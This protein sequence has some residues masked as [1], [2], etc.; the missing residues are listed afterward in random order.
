[1]LP[2]GVRFQ[3]TL[4][5]TPLY[6]LHERLGGKLVPYAGFLMPVLYNGQLHVESH[7]WVRSKCGLFDVLH[8][9]QHR[10]SGPGARAFLE[11]V[12]PADLGALPVFGLTLLV[13][14][15]DKGGVVD[16]TIITKHGDDSFYFVTNAGCRDKDLAFLKAQR[17]PT[18][19]FTHTPFEG[20][21]I[22]LQGPLAA[23]T[24]Q[25]FTQTDLGKLVFGTSAFVDLEIAGKAHVA[26]G[27]YTGEDGFEI[28]I[29]DD[30]AAVAFTEALLAKEA[31]API[32][33]AA[34][35]S[36]RLE[37]GMCLYGHELTEDLTPVDA[38]LLWLVPK[39]RRSADAGF[40][41]A[42]RI[43]SQLADK[44][45]VKSVRVGLTSKGPA[46]RDGSVVYSEAGEPVG[47]VTS[48]S[49]SP[50]VGGNVAQAYVR[51]GSNKLGTK[52]KVDVRGKL[53]DAEITKMPFV[54]THYYRG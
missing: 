16:D 11:R 15:N 20:T 45:L 23:E 21:L 49:P 6:A 7:K 12:L 52:V 1:M 54:E 27:G 10:L 28:S 35:D 40:N 41:G 47:F 36:L 53:R 4:R 34:R 48:G 26:R 13:L 50:L 29:E 31:V 3:L 33:L 32:G 19:D 43:A 2:R 24:L 30:A 46:P 22:A 37:A 42:A 14:L 38:S 8:M 44:K 25:L 5:K 17:L 51:K 18:D 9:L 39:L